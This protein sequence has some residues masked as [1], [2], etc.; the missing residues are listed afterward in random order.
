MLLLVA[1]IQAMWR[2]NWAK[3]MMKRL[4]IRIRRQRLLK[5]YHAAVKI[6][7]NL[8]M[9]VARCNY[10]RLLQRRF[11]G[12]FLVR[13]LLAAPIIVP[14]LRLTLQPFVPGGSVLSPPQGAP[15]AAVQSPD[16]NHAQPRHHQV[17]VPSSW[18]QDTPHDSEPER[19]RHRDSAPGAWPC[20]ARAPEEVGRR[21]LGAAGSN[22]GSSSRALVEGS[23]TVTH[24]WCC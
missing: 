5:E 24:A 15:S 2:A 20:C 10:L 21:C 19:Q 11:E 23:L 6:K 12:S 9:Y 7:R 17:P 1:K 8:R 4:R 16:S 13:S 3:R 14:D 22:A 18:T